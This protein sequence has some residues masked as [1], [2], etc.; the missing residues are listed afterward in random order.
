MS[1]P[2]ASLPAIDILLATYNG[3]RFLPEQLA[4]L[5]AQTHSNWRVILRDDGSSD[6]S[7]Q[8]VR[9]WAR[10]GG[11]DLVVL[12]DGRRNLG[13]K[14]NF[15]ALLEASDAPY[16]ACCDQDDVWLPDKLALMLAR[17]REAEAGLPAGT[18]VLAYSDLQVV[19]E[20]LR[21]VSPSFRAYASLRQPRAGRA[22]IDLM[23]QN[24]VT[25]CALLG[26]AALRAKALP[27]PDEAMMH[28]WWLA[29][30]CAT[31]GR[32]VEIS[33]TTVLYRQ[34]GKNAIGAVRWTSI[35]LAKSLVFNFGSTKARA[36][37]FHHDSRS[38]ARALA[39]KFGPMI[40]PENAKVVV[41]YAALEVSSK[42][43]KLAFCAKH[44]IQLRRSLRTIVAILI[45]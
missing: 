6:G 28:D 17:L 30:V 21:Q 40:T 41:R 31:A 3:A 36:R 34:H 37:A 2:H 45:F 10:A 19:D 7:E 32:L 4:S 20:C 9:R 38:Q 8:I 42:I 44:G 18:P 33:E 23:T 43:E 5:A 25:G 39:D 22:V 12:E 15:A 16:F 13:A 26:N 24:V 35:A 1:G 27:I 11:H 29:M 14:G